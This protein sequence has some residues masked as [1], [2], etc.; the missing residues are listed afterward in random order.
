MKAI[1]IYDDQTVA[2][3]ANAMLQ[4]AANYADVAIHWHISPWRMDMLKFSAIADEALAMAMDAHLIIFAGFHHQSLPQ[5]LHDWLE[6]WVVRRQIPGVALAL[7]G[8]GDDGGASELAKSLSRFAEHHDLNVITSQAKPDESAVCLS[9]N[10]ENVLTYSLVQPHFLS[11]SN[12]GAYQN[13]G[14]NE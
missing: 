2:I 13:W 4:R 11:L 6:K 12:R 5:C 3:S 10:P 9:N 7:I 8:D 14:L 1:I